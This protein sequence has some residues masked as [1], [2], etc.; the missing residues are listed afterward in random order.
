MCGETRGKLQSTSSRIG[1]WSELA[2]FRAEELD[3]G[4][5]E[6]SMKRS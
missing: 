1:R 2:E 4:I 5:S 3:I 6:V